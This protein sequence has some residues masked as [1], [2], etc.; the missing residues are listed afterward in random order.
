MQ[1]PDSMRLS[2][3]DLGCLALWRRTRAG[4]APPAQSP[5]AGA[6]RRRA[7][8]PLDL[9][10]GEFGN[11]AYVGAMLALVLALAGSAAGVRHHLA[12]HPVVNEHVLRAV[13][14]PAH[15]VEGAE[16]AVSALCVSKPSQ[17][18]PRGVVR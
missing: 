4:R 1:S 12:A 18:G 16:R 2:L 17:D 11:A 6:P 9:G 15:S 7:A 10:T 3:F 8:A 14:Q 13:C 5:V